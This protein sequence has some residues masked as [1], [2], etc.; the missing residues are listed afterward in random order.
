MAKVN[1]GQD[2]RRALVPACSNPVKLGDRVAALLPAGQ[3]VKEAFAA[4]PSSETP[5]SEPKTKPTKVSVA[6]YLGAID[7]A[8][9]RADCEGLVKLMRKITGQ[10]PVIWG[11]SI[12][13]FGSYRYT[14]ESGHS[15]VSCVTGFAARKGDISIYLVA[16]SP[17]QQD[18]L[19]R[20]GKHRMGKACLYIKRLSD[21]DL[22][23]LEQLVAASVV[24][25]KRRY[26]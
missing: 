17:D 5:M 24:E 1:F 10:E 12:V 19:L 22:P 20:L 14:Y 8:T 13:G 26:P 15:G 4:I 7:D 11:S 3:A 25:V 18:L 9:R 6:E 21:I 16:E 2:Y 23:T